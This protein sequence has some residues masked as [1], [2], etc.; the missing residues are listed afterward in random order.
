MKLRFVWGRWIPRSGPLHLEADSKD[1]RGNPVKVVVD[2]K[3]EN[4]GSHNRTLTGTWT[5][6]TIKGTFKLTRE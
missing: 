2:G 4:I 6:G 3:L 5:R 1:E